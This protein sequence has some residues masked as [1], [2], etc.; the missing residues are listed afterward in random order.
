MSLWIEGRAVSVESQKQP[1]VMYRDIPEALIYTSSTQNEK[2][3][4]RKLKQKDC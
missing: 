3:G 2:N 4:M 1:S